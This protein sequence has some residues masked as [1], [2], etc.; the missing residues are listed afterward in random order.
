MIT[1]ERNNEIYVIATKNC[2]WN[3]IP[4][5]GKK[6]F[7]TKAEAEARLKELQADKQEAKNEKR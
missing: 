3:D 5:I 7:V 4:A 1:R 6:Y 2:E